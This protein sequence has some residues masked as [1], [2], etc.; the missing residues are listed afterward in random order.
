MSTF[1]DGALPDVRLR[2][3]TLP[4]GLRV[5]LVPEHT[6]NCV[7]VAV[8]YRVGFR[9]DPPGHD[10]LAHLLEHLMFQRADRADRAHAVERAGGYRNAAT[11][12][13]TTDFHQVGPAGS[14]ESMLAT[15]ADRMR[16]PG[17]DARTLRTETNVVA[18]E[19]RRN[20]T[21]R[22]YGGFPKFA[23]PRLLYRTHANAHDGYGDAAGLART[24]VEQCQ[25]FF[26]RHYAPGNALLTVVGAF[27][28][29]TA[30]QLVL[31]HF[32]AVPART[33]ARPPLLHEPEPTTELHG[34]HDDPLAPLPATTIGYRLP[35]PV[36]DLPGYLA[37][38]L[39]AA[40]LEGRL[41]HRLVL[42]Q[43]AAVAVT[44]TCGLIGGP[45][46][47]CHPQTFACTVTQPAGADHQRAVTAVDTEL[48]TLARHG[49]TG[50]ELL[51]TTRRWISGLL[52]RHDSLPARLRSLG[53]FELLHGDAA[54]HT[55]VSRLAAATDAADIARAAQ[56]L[57]AAGRAVLTLSPR[58][59]APAAGHGPAGRR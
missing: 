27:D 40:V 47:A 6:G 57:T 18:E 42:E 11:G 7:G 9:S 26:A 24:T 10:G 59:P 20:I 4:N 15:E 54:L 48:S 33:A 32:G 37:H 44:A 56:R 50:E 12:P 5:L 52:R 41:R 53:T 58:G 51:V 13:D 30:E 23:L 31:R 17:I 55:R 3:R 39:L 22:P 46:E 8:H 1:D 49:A 35:D 38:V 36:A 16:G 43:R 25:D 28:T 29:G 45:F 14:L 19:I 2:R 34:R 21:S